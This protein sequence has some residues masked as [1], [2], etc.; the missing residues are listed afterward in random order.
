MIEK[1][2]ME[3]FSKRPGLKLKTKELGKKLHASSPKKYF[4]LKEALY[5]LMQ[6]GFLEKSGKRFSQAK[7][8]NRKLI[9]VFQIA[10]QGTYGFVI[11][12][13]SNLHDIFIPE[14]YFGI[15]FHGDIVEVKL[16]SNKRGKNIE[17]KIEKIIRRKFDEVIGSV[18]KRK[19]DYF[20]ESNDKSIH[21]KFLIAK[22][23]LNGAKPG[24]LVVVH[25]ILWEQNSSTPEGRITEVLGKT[26]SLGADTAAIA[27]EFDI[28][29]QFPKSVENELNNLSTLIDQEEIS[30]RLDLRD[31]NVFT[32]DPID[33]KDFDDAISIKT[34]ENG[35]KLVGIHI[36]DVS[37]YVRK[38]THIYNEALKRGTSVYL[39]GK[40]VPMLP[41]KLSNKICSLVPNEDRLTFSVIVELDQNAVVKNYSITKSIINS[42]RRF[43]YE[44]VQ[45]ILNSGSGDFKNEISE[46]NQVAHKLR[47]DRN[48]KGSINFSR[49][50]VK[51][52]L[53]EN[54]KPISVEVKVIQ[55]SNQLIEELMLLANL[56][57]A[58]H[59]NKGDI[60]SPFPFVYRI[61]DK[62]EESKLNEFALFVQSLGYNFKINSKNLSKEFQNLLN[63]VEGTAEE[64]VVN[65]IA[66]RTMAKAIY[67]NLNIGHYGLG[68]KHYTHFT[69]PIRRFPDL[70]V[71]L[72][73]YYYL[74]N[75]NK[76]SYS[77]DEIQEI[78]E[79]CS[80]Q[81]R[82]AISAER[83]SVKLKQIELL[84]DKLG[85]DFV[86]IVSGVT[87]FGL[88][89]E[90][91]ENLAQG[92]V[93]LSD[94]DDDYYEFN[95]KN[96]SLIGRRTKKVFRLG[97]RITIKLIRVDEERREV[98]FLIVE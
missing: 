24:D 19:A 29:T 97:D 5:K 82:N 4:N 80:L 32:I 72:Q 8:S 68:F 34:L 66:I 83:L 22:E 60:N 59:F 89:V 56:T 41:E 37:H 30:K 43:T 71:H 2:I 81:E 57:I 10:K 16:L 64:A 27:H 98:D 45:E 75:N 69:S 42:K 14:K 63:Q 44:E 39:V 20:V 50:E 47:D 13:N 95:E 53:D 23:N 96:Y 65:E 46:L 3:Y 73:T 79:H 76:P 62:P 49:P 77:S 67:S 11:L 31:E 36:A 90:I 1:E 54:G 88:F 93:R 55:E 48:K 91:S 85:N 92:L 21:T 9:G 17:G 33:A 51:F 61:H 38:G 78:C 70:L 74:V 12:K 52:E 58:G 28:Q 6:D 7:N 35:N 26:D 94:I 25:D 87:N 84:K 86:G 40:V 15:A 18:T